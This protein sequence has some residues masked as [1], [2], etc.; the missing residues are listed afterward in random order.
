MKAGFR[1]LL[2]G[3]VLLPL[4]VARA[5]PTAAEISAAF[6]AIDTSGNGAISRAEWNASV[7]QRLFRT[8]RTRTGQLRHTR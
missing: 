5:L 8:R 6:K 3:L 1:T 4:S 2:L 7:V